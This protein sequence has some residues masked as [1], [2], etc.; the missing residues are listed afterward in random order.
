MK[1]CGRFRLISPLMLLACALCALG[2][3][4]RSTAA[5]APEAPPTLSSVSEWTCD[6]RPL[7]RG[8]DLDLGESATVELSDGSQATVK[9]L[10]LTETRDDVRDAVR[11]A[12]VE[13]EVNGERATIVSATYHLPTTVG[14]VQVDCPITGGHLSNSRENNWRLGKDARLRLWPGGSPWIRRGTFVYPV[15]QRWFASDTQIG[16]EPVFVDGPEPVQKE[17]IYYHNGLDLGG[18][19]GAV[20]VL[21][22][23]DGLVVQAR[24]EKLADAYA[25]L[26][27]DKVSIM[28]RRGW[29]HGYYHLQSIEPWVKPGVI[30]KMGQRIG[31]LGK[32]SHS[33]GWAHLHFGLWNRQP[34]RRNGSDEGYAFIWQAYVDQYSPDVIAVARPHHLLW[35]RQTARL[36]G[37]RSW[38]ASGKIAAYDWTFTDG[39]TASGPIIERRYDRPGVYSEVLKIT[40]GAG[41]VGYDFAVVQVLDR[42]NPDRNPPSIN[43]AYWPT[44]DLKAGQDITF[45]VRTFKTTHGEEAWD[46]GDGSAGVTTKSDGCV[47]PLA[48]DGYAHTTHRYERPGDYIVTVRRANEHS[49]EAIGHLHVTVGE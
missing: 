30:V 23:V 43:A 20:P 49:A 9:L 44:F 38:S 35:A 4:G 29:L 12:E 47:D 7:W 42:D 24:E 27:Y 17:N 37:S 1:E 5:A 11:R 36:D 33:G 16:N 48:K 10:G 26:R 46:F 13:V 41:H 25:S 14:G 32:E 39:G 31:T 8:I 22:S 28:D 40:D 45:A 15:E 6:L 3:A 19:E 34:S 21:A 2:A 18:V